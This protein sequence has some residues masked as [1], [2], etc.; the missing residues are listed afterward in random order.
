FRYKKPDIGCAA[1]RELWDNELTAEA[2]MAKMGLR[3][4]S[5]R[6]IRPRANRA[7]AAATPGGRLVEACEVSRLFGEIAL[8]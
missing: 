5:N 1:V 6:D 7:A 3:Q 2:N 4:S 8:S